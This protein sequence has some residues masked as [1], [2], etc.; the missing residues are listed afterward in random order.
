MELVIPVSRGIL[1]GDRSMKRPSLVM[2]L[3][4][5]LWGHSDCISNKEQFIEINFAIWSPFSFPEFSPYFLQILYNPF[6]A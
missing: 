4:F 6:H 2:F 5:L 3:M 1:G